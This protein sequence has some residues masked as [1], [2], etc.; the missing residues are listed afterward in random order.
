MG[1]LKEINKE[2]KYEI[3]AASPSSAL[4]LSIEN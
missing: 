3:F 2:V 1:A 4:I